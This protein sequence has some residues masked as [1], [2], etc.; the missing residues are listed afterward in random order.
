MVPKKISALHAQVIAI[1]TIH[2]KFLHPPLQRYIL[3]Y[4]FIFLGRLIA[5]AYRELTVH[6]PGPASHSVVTCM[7]TVE[8]VEENMSENLFSS[9]AT[10]TA[11]IAPLK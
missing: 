4:A 6:G 7:C 5:T 9:T 1:R 10:A 3:V 2:P 8:R 11:Y